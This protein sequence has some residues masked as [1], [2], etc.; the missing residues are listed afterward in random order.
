MLVKAGQD[1]EVEDTYGQT[2]LH[3]AALR[4]NLDAAEY[5]VMEVRFALPVLQH[6]KAGSNR[7]CRCGKSRRQFPL[8]QTAN[9]SQ[10][11]GLHGSSVQTCTA[12][13]LWCLVPS[14]P[15]GQHHRTSVSSR[16]ST[17]RCC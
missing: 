5:L 10:C 16:M 3:L 14:Y 15:E 1:P 2:P 11:S 12:A 8:F 4:G 17:T 6:Q 7:S 9:A 13:L